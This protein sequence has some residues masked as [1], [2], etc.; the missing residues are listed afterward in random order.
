MCIIAAK[1]KGKKDLPTA[2][3]LAA[4]WEN[5]PHGAGIMWTDGNGTVRVRKFTETERAAFD[6]FDASAPYR[7]APA[8]FAVAWHFRI[9]THGSKSRDNCHPF[10]CSTTPADIVKE[11]AHRVPVAMHNG[12]FHGIKTQGDESDTRAFVRQVL[13][14]FYASARR[15][16]RGAPAWSLPL[17]SSFIA[18]SKVAMLHPDGR[19]D[20]LNESAGERD[21]GTGVWYSNDSHRRRV[22]YAGS[23]AAA[24][25][26]GYRQA[27]PWEDY[28]GAT[29]GRATYAETLRPAGN[30]AAATRAEKK[31]AKRAE[32]EE[33]RAWY[34]TAY[35]RAQETEPLE[36]YADPA[37]ASAPLATT[38][39]GRLCWLNCYGRRD[40]APGDKPRA[41]LAVTV[42]AKAALERAKRD[43]KPY[44]VPAWTFAMLNPARQAAA[45]L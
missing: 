3:T 37:E 34:A 13:A 10:A 8:R 36:A 5:N 7:K 6:A 24:A 11:G 20:I 15:A 41:L 18:G 32:R 40:P 25:F 16:A 28:A 2:A 21:K 1:E 33:R 19:F 44:P 4:C 30:Y 14:P 39:D 43:G 17:W 26:D 9:A 38:S 31:A 42:V 27:F 35:D 12:I 29:T 22:S 23:V 45:A